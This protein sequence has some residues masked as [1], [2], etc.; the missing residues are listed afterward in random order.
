M[1]RATIAERL[2]FVMGARNISQ[3][4]I[5]KMAEPICLRENAKLS[6]SKLSQYVS[7]KS[8]PDQGM[9]DILAEV[10]DVNPAWLAGYDAP[11]KR[12]APIGDDTADERME[13]MQQL[14]PRLSPFEQRRV[15]AELEKK[16]SEI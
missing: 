11:M 13:K 15:L 9:I 16:A 5:L 8:R 3:V 10:L 6:K 1:A 14:F 4:L 12:E 7:G 2:R